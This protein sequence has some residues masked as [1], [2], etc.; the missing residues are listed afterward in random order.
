MESDRSSHE[1]CV[2]SAVASTSS[3]SLPGVATRAVTRARLTLVTNAPDTSSTLASAA[4][5]QLLLPRIAD[6]DES[7]VR[8]VVARYGALVWSLVRRW[9]NE[10]DDAEDAVQD[11]FIDVWRTAA[12]F[13]PTLMSEAGWV[14]MLTRRRL[15]DRGRKRERTPAL[16]PFPDGFDVEDESERDNDDVIDRQSRSSRALAILRALPETQRRLLELSLLDGKTHDE[17]ARETAL[18][19]GTVKSHLRRG[20]QRARSML[21]LSTVSARAGGIR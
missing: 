2:D 4:G 3:E 7:A 12:R 20:L 1:A 21:A 14:A 16:D 18:P 15:I 11:V 13:D 9:T 19:L 8:E 5:D 17:I 10:R 6:G